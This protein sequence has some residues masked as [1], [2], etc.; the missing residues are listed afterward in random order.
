MAKE[1][2]DKQAQQPRQD[3]QRAQ[4]KPKKEGKKADRVGV[5]TLQDGR[6]VRVFKDNGEQVD[7]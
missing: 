3:Q 5:K 2:D 7:A 1:K 6:K 4:P